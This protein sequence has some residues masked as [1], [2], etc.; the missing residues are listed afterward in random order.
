MELNMNEVPILKSLLSPSM[1]MAYEKA[2]QSGLTIFN[3][4]E[5]GNAKADLSY[6]QIYDR[7][8]ELLAF[9]VLRKSLKYT[10]IDT[11]KLR[12][13]SYITKFGDG[14]EIGYKE[15]YAVDVHEIGFNYHESPTQYKYLEDAAYE[16]MQKHYSDTGAVV[17]INI[18]YDPLRVF[19]GDTK[20]PGQKLTDVKST[21][22]VSSNL[23]AY[24]RML[25]KFLNFDVNSSKQEDIDY[26]NKMSEF[27]SYHRTSRNLRD[28][29]IVSEWIDR[30]R[31]R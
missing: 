3:D 15:E 2:K 28:I 30:N 11:G 6:R 7:T 22:M 17:P 4:S 21:E 9:N 13:S 31:H 27:F 10:P 5:E 1:Y 24:E 8:I 20:A 12:E 16:V 29:D 19:I 23:K 18:E 26:Y 25:D 14:Y